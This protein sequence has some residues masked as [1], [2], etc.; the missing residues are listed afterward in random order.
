MLERRSILSMLLMSMF[1]AR[2]SSAPESL[3][4]GAVV[5]LVGGAGLSAA[6]AFS[7]RTFSVL[8]L[9]TRDINRATWVL[10]VGLPVLLL[11][12][13]RII[14]ASVF[15]PFEDPWSWVFPVTPV[16][17]FYECLLF[18]MVGAWNLL[19]PDSLA[20]DW[21]TSGLYLFV[22]ATLGAMAVP[23]VVLLYLPATFAGISTLGWLLTSVAIA[24]AA[25]PLF[26]SPKQFVRPEPPPPV[27]ETA[28]K[29]LAAG[30]VASGLL[31]APRI[32]G[33]WA[34][35]PRVMA[36]ALVWSAVFIT[37]HLVIDW[38]RG[39]E[40]SLQPFDPGM[41]GV[42]AMMV[43]SFVLLFVIGWLP[44]LGTRV[45]M[46]KLLP[47]PATRAAVVL[48][49]APVMTPLVFWGALILMHV[50][51]STA[52]PETQRLQYLVTMAGLAAVVD[53]LGIKSGSERVKA[54]IGFTILFGL[55]FAFDGDRAGLERMLQHRLVP[56]VG[57]ASL[58]LAYALNLHTMT[59]TERGSRAFRYGQSRVPQGAR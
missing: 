26:L 33:V 59:R 29:K 45:P 49:L 16:R 21:G 28:P 6:D 37:F 43:T 35:L 7:T 10:A 47:V 38:T 22:L 56:A 50:A 14:S 3:I 23:F 8:P 27:I 58:A 11:T 15:A 24:L 19:V 48:T 34:L 39:S 51:V 12:A 9:D 53:A 46:L 25:T 41:S 2:I 57:V 4:G 13:G 32:T 44:S 40:V 36:Q 1:T 31:P 54:A 20:P 52:W 42:R 5:L 30:A 55:A 18:A 17:V